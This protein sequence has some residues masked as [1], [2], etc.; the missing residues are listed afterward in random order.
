LKKRLDKFTFIVYTIG[1]VKD[2]NITKRE[3]TMKIITKAQQL[4][5]EGLPKK[6]MFKFFDVVDTKHN[7]EVSSILG[8]FQ[9]AGAEV[10]KVWDL[11][12]EW[13]EA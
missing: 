7:A 13:Q 1:M 10:Q 12:E 5:S 11:Y 9:V 3:A 6:E 4:V 8:L 2:N